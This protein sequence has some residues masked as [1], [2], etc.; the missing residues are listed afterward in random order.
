M[1]HNI[2]NLSAEDRRKI[3]MY[4]ADYNAMIAQIQEALNI[5]PKRKGSQGMANLLNSSGDMMGT[6]SS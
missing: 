2:G 5:K 1:N 6:E 4:N 3:N